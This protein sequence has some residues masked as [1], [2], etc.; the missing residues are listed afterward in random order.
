MASIVPDSMSAYAACYCFY[1]NQKKKVIKIAKSD[2][3]SNCP[4]RTREKIQIQIA[5]FDSFHKGLWI[6]RRN[7]Q[8]LT[9]R[10][11]KSYTVS[12]FVTLADGSAKVKRQRNIKKKPSAINRKNCL[13]LRVLFIYWFFFCS[14][15]FQRLEM[16]FAQ[17]VYSRP[18]NCVSFV[19]RKVVNCEWGGIAHPAEWIINIWIL[20]R[21]MGFS[22][23]NQFKN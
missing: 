2:I 20:S 15:K 3:S 4:R 8:R 23:L 5:A 14:M 21:M 9:W 11:N 18:A 10:N 6:G 22:S 16:F 12:S 13:Y 7:G 1:Q 19:C 17:N